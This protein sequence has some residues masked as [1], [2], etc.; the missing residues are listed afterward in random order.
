MVA[1]NDAVIIKEGIP[2]LPCNTRGVVRSTE[3]SAI[4]EWHFFLSL[5][6][7]RIEKTEVKYTCTNTYY[8]DVTGKKNVNGQNFNVGDIVAA[9]RALPVEYN[10]AARVVKVEADTVLVYL[11]FRSAVDYNDISVVSPRQ[12]I[13]DLITR[14]DKTCDRE[15]AMQ[16]ASI[17][18]PSECIWLISQP[19][20]LEEALSAVVR[21][22]KSTKDTHVIESLSPDQVFRLIHHGWFKE[23]VDMQLPVTSTSWAVIEKFVFD[24]R[25]IVLYTGSSRGVHQVCQVW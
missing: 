10:S 7:E 25:L 22:I 12:S 20:L 11:S 1:N 5:S 19:L 15:A 3:T 16:L 2:A 24:Y 18:L 23:L 9:K 17:A 8:V 4:V 6:P 21:Y 14:V 13:E